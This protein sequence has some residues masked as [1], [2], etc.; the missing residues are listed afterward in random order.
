MEHNMTQ[1]KEWKIIL[2]F[3]FPLIGA[4]FLQTLYSFADS[5]IVG[6]FV[7]DT[8]FGAIGMLSPVIMLLNFFCTAAGNS[9]SILSAQYYGAGK[10]KD[11]R[12]T[13]FT[14]MILSLAI[15][16]VI[17]SICFAGARWLVVDFL[18]TPES[19]VKDSIT[20]LEIYGVGL[21]FQT[22]YQVSYGVLR[23]HGD[24]KGAMVFLFVSAVINVGL[25]LLFII[26]FHWGVMGGAL[27]TIISQAGSAIASVIYLCRLFPDVAYTKKE[28]WIYAGEKAGKIIRLAIPILCQSSI[29]SIGFIVLQRLCN[30]FGEPSI[31]GYAAMQKVES[32]IHIV[33]SALNV[34]MS[35]FT[36]QNMGAGRADRVIRGYRLTA[37]MGFLSSAMIAIPMIVFDCQLLSVFNIGDEA[38][39]RGCE[40][41]N[42]LVIFMTVYAVSNITAGLLQGSGDVKIPAITSFVN[43]FI[44]VGS[45]YLMAG[46]FVGYRCI[47]WSLPLAWTS[48][49]LINFL[50]YKSGLWKT[51]ILL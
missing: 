43:L 16:L 28:N 22:I 25:D 11:V 42:I 33:P 14:G 3:S 36:G 49:F 27:A 8:A 7:G 9:V 6:N 5:V 48:A 12:E 38:L 2:L 30:S 24:S 51:K 35:T 45:S 10:E 19:M 1:G 29:L 41:L 44:R 17:I 39:K 47:F 15:S 32:F 34:A 46:T 26:G 18:H 23:A 37:L 50:R 4:S 40:H 31:E 21:F 13:S 20:Y